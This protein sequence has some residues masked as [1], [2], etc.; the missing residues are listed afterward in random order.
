MCMKSKNK[1]IISRILKILYDCLMRIQCESKYVFIQSDIVFEI[2][3]IWI[4]RFIFI[5]HE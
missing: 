1:N 5:L 4:V 3:F 2:E